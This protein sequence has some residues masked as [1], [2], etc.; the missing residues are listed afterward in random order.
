MNKIVKETF[1]VTNKIIDFKV[2]P[3]AFEN[4]SRY[5][6]CFKKTNNRNYHKKEL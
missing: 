2:S 5:Y 4:N 6:M 1:T 3:L